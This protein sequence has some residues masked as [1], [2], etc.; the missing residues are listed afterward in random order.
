MARRRGVREVGELLSD[1]LETRE[2]HIMGL[3]VKRE[4]AVDLIVFQV[5]AMEMGQKEID[6]WCH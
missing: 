2:L 5:K 4:L 3:D 6:V 1:L